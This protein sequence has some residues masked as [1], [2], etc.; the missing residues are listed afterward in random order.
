VDKS[1]TF[2][3]HWR[4]RNG[5]TDM[6]AIH[7]AALL[8]PGVKFVR[9]VSS[10]TLTKPIYN[11]QSGEVDWDI[12]QLSAT[13]GTVGLPVETVFQISLTPAINQLGQPLSLLG[14]SSLQAT[15]S[16][17]GLTVK[18]TA[19]EKDSNLSDDPRAG[20]GLVTQ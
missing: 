7:V 15:D 12:P 3:I 16:F 2:T 17:T 8:A 11:A 5:I 6:N 4:L 14:E 19:I 13:Q 9:S 10:T 1:T 18:T 20:N